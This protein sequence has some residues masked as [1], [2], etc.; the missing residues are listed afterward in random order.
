MM[1]KLYRA[2]YE[3]RLA[4]VCAGLGSY[5]RID[6]VIVRLVFIF[7]MMIT[8]VIP[9]LVVYIIFALIL[10][11]EP[12][13]SRAFSYKHLTRDPRDRVVAGVCSGLAH[14]FKMDPTVMRLIFVVITLLTAIFPMAIAYLV[15][16]FII[17]EKRS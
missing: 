7:L 12:K 2:R 16:T 14:F 8:G 5:F 1:R 6:P 4:G 9:M 10:P 11:L 13:H 15:G 3:K 17:P